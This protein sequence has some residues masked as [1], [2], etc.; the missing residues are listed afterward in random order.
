MNEYEHILW[1]SIRGISLKESVVA[2]INYNKGITIVIKKTGEVE[3][4]LP[5][6][7]TEGYELLITKQLKAHGEILEHIPTLIDNDYRPKHLKEYQKEFER[8]VSCIE[9]GCMEDESGYVSRNLN[10]FCSFK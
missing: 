6:P 4:C 5:H 2:G 9:R 8:W 3:S 1:K 7:N 10:E